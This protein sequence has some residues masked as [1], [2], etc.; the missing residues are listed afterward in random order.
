M[1]RWLARIIGAAFLLAGVLVCLNWSGE[2]SLFS[3]ECMYYKALAGGQ[4]WCQLCPRKCVV[5][6]GRRGACGIRQNEGGKFFLITYGKPCALGVEPIEKAPFFH[7]HPGHKR[8]V[9]ATV[10]CVLR[11]RFCQNWNISQAAF[12]DVR[13]M[14]VSP[15]E[16]VDAAVKQGVYSICFTFTEPVVFYEYMYDIARL[17]RARGIKT[18]MVSS[19]YINPEPLRE[20]LKVVDAVKID[21]KGFTEKFYADMAAADLQP[22]L[23]SIKIVKKSGRWLELVNLV[24]PGHNDDPKDIEL[25]CRWIKDHVGADVPV[26]FTRFFPAYRLASVPPT[27]VK[28]LEGAYRIA[29][30]A[31]LRYVYVGNVPGHALENTVCPKCG[32]TVIERKGYQVSEDKVRDGRCPF[33][34]ERLSGLW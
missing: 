22:V 8:L 2:K 18:S 10:G 1:R 4:V 14:E 26:H 21:L 34:N 5:A 32:K 6:Q 29:K 16:V 23:E 11:C 9:V 27:P 15:A 31:G 7:F 3:R 30:A 20:L 28:T 25:M 19:G 12:E 24:I 17:A 33:C 13:Y